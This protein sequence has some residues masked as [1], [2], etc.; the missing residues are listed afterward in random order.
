[1]K[2][3]LRPRNIIGILTVVG[4]FVAINYYLN[5]REGYDGTKEL[6]LLHMNGCGHCK[7]LMPEWDEFVANND[8]GIKTRAVEVN[9]DP[10]LAKKHGVTGFPTILLLGENGDKVDT[11][12]GERTAEGLA[13][14]C[15]QN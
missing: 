7:K 6:L 2:F 10:S 4:L 15:N 3:L 13:S 12:D 1:M 11:Y 9:E 5:L 14:Y 8:S